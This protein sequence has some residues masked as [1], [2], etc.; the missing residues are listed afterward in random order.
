MS[1]VDVKGGLYIESMPLFS[2]PTK[3]VRL[4]DLVIS[5]DIESGDRGPETGSSKWF[6]NANSL[7][8]HSL[9]SCLSRAQ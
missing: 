5:G 9:I 2:F 7:G 1:L 6:V 8:P 4:S 3:P